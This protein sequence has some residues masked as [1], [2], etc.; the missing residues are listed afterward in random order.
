MSLPSTSPPSVAVSKSSMVTHRSW[1]P[2]EMVKCAINLQKV[3]NAPSRS[4]R[5]LSKYFVMKYHFSSP[6]WKNN[7]IPLFTPFRGLGGQR[8]RQPRVST[9]GFLFEL[10]RQNV[11]HVEA[12]RRSRHWFRQCGGRVHGEHGELKI[13]VVTRKSDSEKSLC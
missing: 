9:R 12:Q 4:N 8:K 7:L 6:A 5:V 13:H 11:S 2:S 10:Y 1:L 3:K